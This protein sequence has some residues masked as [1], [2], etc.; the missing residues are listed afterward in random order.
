M[1]AKTV[2]IT[3]PGGEFTATLTVTP[4]MTVSEALEEVGLDKDFCLTPT[5]GDRYFGPGDRLEEHVRD[6]EVLH[7]F[8]E[9]TLGMGNAFFRVARRGCRCSQLADPRHPSGVV[10]A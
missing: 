9:A 5:N 3:A 4:E 2:T 10:W 7:A 1:A 6:G 8:R